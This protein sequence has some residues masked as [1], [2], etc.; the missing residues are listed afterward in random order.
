M[1]GSIDGGEQNARKHEGTMPLGIHAWIYVYTR[2]IFRWI[3]KIQIRRMRTG[4]IWLR[5]GNFL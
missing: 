4:S 2:I 5:T 1:A 3:L